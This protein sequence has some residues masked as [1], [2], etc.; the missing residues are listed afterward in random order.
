MIKGSVEF[1]L[2]FGAYPEEPEAQ[3][4]KRRIIVPAAWLATAFTVQSAVSDFQATQGHLADRLS[5]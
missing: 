4:G 1:M 2:L 3:R 5:P